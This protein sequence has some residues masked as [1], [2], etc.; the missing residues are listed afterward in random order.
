MVNAFS[1]DRTDQPFGIGILP[2]RSRR[3]RSISDDAGRMIG[4]KRT[5]AYECFNAA[6]NRM[7]AALEP[8]LRYSRMEG[9]EP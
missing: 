4:L 2:R 8:Y 3:G 5:A 1:P 6:R 9:A 7:L